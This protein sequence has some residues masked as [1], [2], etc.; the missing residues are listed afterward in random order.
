MILAR[1]KRLDR[2]FKELTRSE[3]FA[4]HMAMYATD[5]QSPQVSDTKYIHDQAVVFGLGSRAL[6]MR[7]GTRWWS[8]SGEI[9]PARWSSRRERRREP[10]S[11]SKA[12]LI[13]ND[14]N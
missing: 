11:S 5:E 10:V 2:T 7:T 6:G 1:R 4:Y 14:R 9:T 8:T 3:G 12:F 13:Q